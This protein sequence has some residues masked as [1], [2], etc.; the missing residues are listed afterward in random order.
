[1]QITGIESVEF[2]APDMAEA[3]TLFSD[4]ACARLRPVALAVASQPS[5][6]R[7]W[8]CVRSNHEHWHR[9]WAKAISVK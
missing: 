3:R 4:W 2:G 1:M 8:W 7:A 5:M 9:A 6:A